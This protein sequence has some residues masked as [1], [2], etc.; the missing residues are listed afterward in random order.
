MLIFKTQS[1]TGK[2]RKAPTIHKDINK[3]ETSLCSDI[4]NGTLTGVDDEQIDIPPEIENCINR[5]RC[6]HNRIRA[7]LK[8]VNQFY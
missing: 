8:K 1:I 4:N 2:S 6:I 7:K 3:P 5:N